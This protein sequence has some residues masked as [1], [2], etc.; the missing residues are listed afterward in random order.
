MS[1]T[2]RALLQ[3]A[4]DLLTPEGTWTQHA[5]A[6]TKTDLPT[7]PKSR[8]ATCWCVLGA[9]ERSADFRSGNGVL[10]S[11][12]AQRALYDALPKTVAGWN[13]APDRTQPEVLALLDRVIAKL[14][15]PCDTADPARQPLEGGN[16]VDDTHATPEL[17]AR[18]D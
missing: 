9:L 4:R 13:D 14:P 2:P 5:R 3:R 6:K 11:E 8:Y 16:G 17:A 15:A 18:D 10:A 1:D 12:L 7:Y